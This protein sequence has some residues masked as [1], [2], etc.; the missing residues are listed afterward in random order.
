MSCTALPLPDS[1]I[2]GLYDNPPGFIHFAED[3][4]LSLDEGGKTLPFTVTSP[5]YFKIFVAPHRIDIDL[6]L[7]DS[8]NKLIEYSLN[9]KGEPDA[10]VVFLQ[11]GGYNMSIIFVPPYTY[12]QKDF[13]LF[14]AY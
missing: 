14:F 4:L 7:Y 13:K 5:S 11:P 12:L 2:P 6:K 10:L 3:V 9:L 1:I 8:T